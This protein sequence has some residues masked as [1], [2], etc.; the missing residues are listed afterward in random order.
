MNHFETIRS[1][2]VFSSLLGLNL[3]SRGLN[4]ILGKAKVGWKQLKL[5]F[6]FCGRR[7]SSSRTSRKVVLLSRK[8]GK[9]AAQW[10]R[11]KNRF[12]SNFLL[13][14]CLCRV[15]WFASTVLPK[16]CTYRVTFYLGIQVHDESIFLINFVV[17][18]Q[19][20]LHYARIAI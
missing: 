9:Q 11:T 4:F 2:S 18:Q 19:Q 12:F 17:G 6:V 20:K 3:E 16:N 14:F 13:G 1:H 7:P 10:H 5:H 8:G 15:T